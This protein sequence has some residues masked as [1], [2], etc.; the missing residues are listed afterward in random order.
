MTTNIK[1]SCPPWKNDPGKS[2]LTLRSVKA[3]ASGVAGEALDGFN[4]P[5]K[6]H[7]TNLH[8]VCDEAFSA[9]ASATVS[10]AIKKGTTAVLSCPISNAST[11]TNVMTIGQAVKGTETEVEFLTTDEMTVYVKTKS[12]KTNGAFIPIVEYEQA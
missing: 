9:K 12:N 3:S 5:R 8:M 10:Y 1:D 11:S 6:V 7:V 2:F 4:F